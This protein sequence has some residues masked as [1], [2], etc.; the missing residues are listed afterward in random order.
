VRTSQEPLGRD[1]N[2]A[3]HGGQNQEQGT[4]ELVVHRS[5]LAPS[6]RLQQGQVEAEKYILWPQAKNDDERGPAAYC[7]G[8][9]G[10][11]KK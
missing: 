8:S 9:R 7:T 3:D 5:S 4:Q 6:S 1:T 2:D 10:V 11:A